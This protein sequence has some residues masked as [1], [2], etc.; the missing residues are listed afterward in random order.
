[1]PS[2]LVLPAKKVSALRSAFS[3][4][5]GTVSFARLQTFIHCCVSSIL[6]IHSHWHGGTFPDPA[7]LTAISAFNIAPYASN[8]IPT[9]FGKDQG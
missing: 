4:A 6:L 5:D 2:D 8:K 1:M 7:T 3:E 9:M